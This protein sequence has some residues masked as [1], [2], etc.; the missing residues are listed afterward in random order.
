MSL[1]KD[2]QQRL[3]E[4]AEASI[5]H[6][7]KTG[8]PLKINLA[9]FPPELREQ[10]ASFVTLN[11][12]HRLRG[13]IGM[14][15][16]IRPVAEDIAENA[17]SAAFKDTRFPPLTSQEFNDLQ[18]HLSI[19]TPAEPLSFTS[20]QDL[21]SQLQPGIDGL[22]LQ[23]GSRRG[24]FLPSVWESLPKPVQFLNQL[25]QKAGLPANYWSNTISVSRYRAESFG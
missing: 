21:I 25:K 3:V 2:H 12:N 18:I 7:L 22:I 6:G 10:R 5:R 1:N 14:L 9:E 19:L 23:E 20:E 8:R 15:Q 11:I 17:F 24:T 13:C 4:L 16:A